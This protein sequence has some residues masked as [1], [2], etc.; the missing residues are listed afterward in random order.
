M[1]SKMIREAIILAGGLG[2][3]LRS[4]VPDLP[5][6][7]APVAGKPFIAHVVDSFLG[8]GIEKFIFAL[9]YKNHYFEAFLEEALPAGSYQISLEEEPLGTG[10]AIRLACARVENRHVAVLNGDTFFQTDMAALSAF[11]Q[12]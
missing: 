10:G 3:R 1:E 12:E 5:K 8:A 11:H 4:S 6:C 9:G 7:M 2:T